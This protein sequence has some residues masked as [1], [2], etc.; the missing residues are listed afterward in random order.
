[1]PGPAER[2]AL[3][4]LAERARYGG[5]PDHKRNPGDFALTPPAG[6]RH[7]ATLC[8][9]AKVFARDVA[10]GLLKEG[11]RRGLVSVQEW[12]GWPQN[13]WAVTDDGFPMEAELE[14]QEVGSYHGYPMPMSDSFRD[15]VSERWMLSQPGHGGRDAV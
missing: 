8:D 13:V 5:N 3:A 15:N 11:M 10:L 4:T 12:N 1:M 14:N 6:P 9:G 7:G 2:Q